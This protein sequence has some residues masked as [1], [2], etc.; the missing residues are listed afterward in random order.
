MARISGTLDELLNSDD[1]SGLADAWL[2]IT[3]T[4]K[5]R[6]DQP[7]ERLRSRFENVISLRFESAISDGTDDDP[8]HLTEI[9]RV[10][11]IKLIESFIEHVRGSGP[12]PDEEKALQQALESRAAEE[13]R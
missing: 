1:F 9:A 10:D 6:P 4:D 11:P 3:L 8:R 12:D 2:E 5:R 7:M 13:S